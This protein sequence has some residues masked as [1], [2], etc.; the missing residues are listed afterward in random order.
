MHVELDDHRRFRTS[1]G[2]ICNWA[3]IDGSHEP[4]NSGFDLAEFDL[5]EFDLAK[6]GL[7]KFGL[8]KFGLA[9]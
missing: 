5:A 9:I 6:F 3:W 7:A 4:S 1:T 2:P 8:A